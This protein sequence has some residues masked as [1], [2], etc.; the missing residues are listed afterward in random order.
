MTTWLNKDI[1][2]CWVSCHFLRASPKKKGPGIFGTSQADETDPDMSFSLE[3]LGRNKLMLD[4]ELNTKRSHSDTNFP[5]ISHGFTWFIYPRTTT[6]YIYIYVCIYIKILHNMCIYTY[7]Y[8]ICYIYI[9]MI[10]YIYIYTYVYVLF[11]YY[12]YIFTYYNAMRITYKMN[13]TYI[14]S[15]YLSM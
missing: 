9:Y 7:I 3:L 8:I 14:C 15:I 1:I 4:G 5:T 2:T 6:V 10:C 13:I 12:M 11:T